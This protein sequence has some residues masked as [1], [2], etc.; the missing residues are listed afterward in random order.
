MLNTAYCCLHAI[1]HTS[2]FKFKNCIGGKV[3]KLAIATI[4]EP[5]GIQDSQLI[6]QRG[7]QKFMRGVGVSAC[8]TFDGFFLSQLKT[9]FVGGGNSAGRT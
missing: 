7:E 1:Y 8:A 2:I 4:I 9:Q 3:L 5:Q 6:V